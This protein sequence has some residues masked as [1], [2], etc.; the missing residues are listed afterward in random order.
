MNAHVNIL[1]HEQAYL[2]AG[3]QWSKQGDFAGLLPSICTQT[4]RATTV[5]HTSTRAVK[6]SVK[7]SIQ[8]RHAV[9]TG[10]MHETTAAIF[11]LR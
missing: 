1:Q 8:P 7:T 11:V 3:G 6:H 9:L 2:H 4:K 10:L 5:T